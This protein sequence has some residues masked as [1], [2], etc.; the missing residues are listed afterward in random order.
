MM[1]DKHLEQFIIEETNNDN[2]A[3]NLCDGSDYQKFM[4]D[5]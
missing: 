5:N 3:K 4:E 2:E 1:K